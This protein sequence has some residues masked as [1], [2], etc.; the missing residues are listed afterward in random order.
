VT[1]TSDPGPAAAAES[2]ISVC[3]LDND[4]PLLLQCL[5]SVLKAFEEAGETSYELSVLSLSPRV[6]FSLDDAV[7]RYPDLRIVV[8]PWF[9]H[10]VDMLNYAVRRSSGRFVLLL[11]SDILL[12]RDFF[13]R[14]APYTGKVNLFGLAFDVRAVSDSR[15]LQAAAPGEVPDGGSELGKTAFADDLLGV[16]VRPGLPEPA[17][18]LFAFGGIGCF[19]REALLKLNGFSPAFKFLAYGFCADLD[20]C[21]RAWQAGYGTLFAP[22]LKV[23]RSGLRNAGAFYNPIPSSVHEPFFDRFA[24]NVLFKFFLMRHRVT[25]PAGEF[26]SSTVRALDLLGLLTGFIAWLMRIFHRGG[27]AGLKPFYG[28]AKIREI[29]SRDAL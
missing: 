6:S 26:F 7:R 24:W 10:R 8:L 9:T 21:Y 13:S 28:F 25:V 20:L 22:D 4:S 11:N 29:T 15:V 16:E 1:E 17:P 18:A 5:M 2:L 19:R 12:A 14:L 3:V 23:W 27:T